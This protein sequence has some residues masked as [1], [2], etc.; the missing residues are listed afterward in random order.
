MLNNRGLS[1][2]LTLF[3]CSLNGRSRAEFVAPIVLYER[4]LKHPFIVY[5]VLLSPWRMPLI[6]L[7]WFGPLPSLLPVLLIE[8]IP[9]N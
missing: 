9:K 1:G 3:I 7:R 5:F 8:H 6:R 4:S 2:L